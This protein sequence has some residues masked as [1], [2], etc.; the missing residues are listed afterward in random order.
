MPA[1][2]L[3]LRCHVVRMGS[4][5]L[6]DSSRKVSEVYLFNFIEGN[7]LIIIMHSI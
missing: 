1:G 7:A 5:D 4:L 3:K 2:T 6:E